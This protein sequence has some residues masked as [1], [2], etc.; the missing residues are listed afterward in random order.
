LAFTYHSWRRT[1]RKLEF[2]SREHGEMRID[3]IEESRFNEL[4]I[5]VMEHTISDILGGEAKKEICLYLKAVV[6]LEVENISKELVVFDAGLKRLF[7]AGAT[8]LENAIVKELFSRIGLEVS[9]RDTFVNL[10]GKAKTYF[11]LYGKRI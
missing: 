8:T 3:S 2:V 7:G 1:P 10:V 9:A 4:F 11:T 5:D 6:F